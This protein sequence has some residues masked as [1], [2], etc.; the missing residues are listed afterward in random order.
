MAYSLT[1]QCIGRAM[2]YVS[3]FSCYV[4]GD[5]AASNIILELVVWIK[6]VSFTSAGIT[7]N[8]QRY[9]PELNN[10]DPQITA[11]TSTPRAVPMFTTAVNN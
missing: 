9:E 8:P 6:L 1:E 7:A 2:T 5:N 10:Y 3:S 4:T 11:D